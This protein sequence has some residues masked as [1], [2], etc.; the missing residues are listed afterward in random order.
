MVCFAALDSSAKFL[1]RSLPTAEVV[2]ARYMIAALAMLVGS[3][4]F[5]RPRLLVANRPGLQFLRSMLLLGATIANFL[6]LKKLQLAETSTI[7]FLLPLF[8][9]LLAG[10]V[11]GEKVGAARFTAILVGF[12]GVLIAM[13]PGTAGFQPIMLLSVA[14]V[15]CGAG[16]ALATRKLAGED[17]PQTTLAWTQTAGIALL[18]PAMPFVWTPPP[19][20]ATWMAL[21]IMGAA[22]A[23]G[24]G[25]LILA[26]QRAPASTLGPFNYTQLIWMII[27]G[28]L[29]FGDAPPAATLVG[30]GLVVVCGLFLILYER[31]HTA[32]KI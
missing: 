4:A 12:F 22:A 19:T 16:Y 5:L 28:W 2:W 6:A 31:R 7:N 32:V 17:A 10:P 11:M 8:I 30:A 1:G 13:R 24:H 9:A 27:S 21:G 23:A 3:R 18:T 25:L 14:G 26:H 29:V 20:A 15:A